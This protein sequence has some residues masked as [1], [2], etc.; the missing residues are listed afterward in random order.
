M[1]TTRTVIPAAPGDALVIVSAGDAPRVF[2]VVAWSW[3]DDAPERGLGALTP[4]GWERAELPGAHAD[5]A[6]RL[7]AVMR[8][9]RLFCGGRA[10][11]TVAAM[12]RHH[13]AGF[14]ADPS[15][16]RAAHHAGVWRGMA[17]GANVNGGE[18]DAW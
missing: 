3:S 9:G 7:H 16:D 14:D 13:A 17:S 5:N 4:H 6:H 8:G 1:L 11:D 10:F 2:P 12:V 18:A 15:D